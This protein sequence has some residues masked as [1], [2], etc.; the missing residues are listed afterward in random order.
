MEN[1]IRYNSANNFFRKKFGQKVIKISLDGG[2]TCPNRD[3]TLSYGG[4]IFCSEKGSGDFAGDRNLDIEEQFKIIRL[5]IKSSATDFGWDVVTFT[6]AGCCDT[7]PIS[8]TQSTISFF[9]DYPFI[10]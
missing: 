7:Q 1:K 2:F 5:N 4:C 9:M 8:N 3:G 6:A 10:K